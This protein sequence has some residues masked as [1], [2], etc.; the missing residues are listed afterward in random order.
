MGVSPMSPGKRSH[1]QISQIDLAT[2]GTEFEGGHGGRCIP[3]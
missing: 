1:T 3:L 2:E